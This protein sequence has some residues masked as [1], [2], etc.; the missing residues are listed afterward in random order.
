MRDFLRNAAVTELNLLMDTLLAVD[1]I[2]SEQVSLLFAIVDELTERGEIP[3]QTEEETNAVLE[4]IKRLI[5]EHS[6]ADPANQAEPEWMAKLKADSAQD[7]LRRKQRR[8]RFLRPT[9]VAASIILALFLTNAVTLAA[10]YDF[11]GSVARWSRDAVYFVFGD[12]AED[13]QTHDINPAYKP[14]KVMLDNL[15]INV[16]L[17]K[18]LPRGFELDAIEPDEP[19]E[20]A[21]IVAWFIRGEAEF[22]IRIKRVATS[23]IFSEIN[24]GA[25]IYRGH[26][27]IATNNNWI[28]AVW[29]HGIYELG[30]HGDL[31]Y[32]ELIRILDSI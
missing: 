21:P 12:P 14:L 2:S 11:F 9:T 17:P 5:T 20:F 3:K 10:G 16:D 18:Y 8:R 26:F 25:E 22:H 7:H 28:A 19:S 23:A 27:M 4:N 29:Y 15:D 30:I 1:D 13:G 6:T 24:E 31:T 32:D